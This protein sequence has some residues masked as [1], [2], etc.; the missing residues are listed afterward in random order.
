[1]KPIIIKRRYATLYYTSV[2]DTKASDVVSHGAAASEQGSIRA[3]VVRIFMG[4][5][6]KAIVVDRELNVP[7]YTIR[8]TSAGLQVTYGRQA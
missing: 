5:Y 6:G 3:T 4:Q 7:I 8:L 2:Q 1:M